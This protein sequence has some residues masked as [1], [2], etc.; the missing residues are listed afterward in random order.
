MTK[1]DLHANFSK[2]LQAIGN[3]LCLGG[4][5][6]LQNNGKLICFHEVLPF[7][8]TGKKMRCVFCVYSGLPPQ[9]RQEYPK[10]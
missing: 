4:R 8:M 3:Q 2:I 1:N 9:V 5:K 7:N 10:V 6:D